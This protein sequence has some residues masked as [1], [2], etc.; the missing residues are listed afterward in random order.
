MNAYQKGF[1]LVE[2]LLAVLVTSI[3]LLGIIKL[4]ATSGRSMTES[5]GNLQTQA[6]AEDLLQEIRLMRW[7]DNMPPIGRMDITVSPLPR[8][9]CII[10]TPRTALE[11]WSFFSGWDDSRPEYGR[12]RRTVTVQFVDQDPTTGG[13]VFSPSPTDRKAVI[14]TAAGRTSTS[15][16]SSVFYNLP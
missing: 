5:M 10:C 14:V 16:I 9:D 4:M 7:D 1:T 3:C 2:V 11:H 6:S 13:L 8:V 12:I 15:T